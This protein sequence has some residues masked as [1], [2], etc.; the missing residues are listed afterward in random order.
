MN[1]QDSIQISENLEFDFDDES[2]VPQLESFIDKL[3][4]QVMRSS[5]FQGEPKD[6]INILNIP[7]IM[8]DCLIGKMTNTERKK[9]SLMN[10]QKKYSSDVLSKL[11]TVIS[12][13]R[14]DI[15]GLDALDTSQLKNVAKEIG[16]GI[17]KK[18]HTALLEEVK[19]LTKIFLAGQGNYDLC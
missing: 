11:M 19:A 7:I 8:P 6:K 4:K 17:S 2:E 14:L 10:V 13:K 12:S 3:A 9:K 1:F 15:L 18:S 16:I 5:F